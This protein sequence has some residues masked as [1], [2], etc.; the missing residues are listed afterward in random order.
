MADHSKKP[1]KKKASLIIFIVELLILLVL[2]T[3]IFGYAKINEGLRNIGT[4]GGRSQTATGTIELAAAND[5]TDAGVQAVQAGTVETTESAAAERE[6]SGEKAA[7]TA[8]GAETVSTASGEAS[9]TGD[10]AEDSSGKKKK[11]RKDKEKE[12]DQDKEKDKEKAESTGSAEEERA[13]T[14]AVNLKGEPVTH[15]SSGKDPNAD[16][17]AAEEN[18][19]IALNEKMRGYTNIVLVG[20]DTRDLNQIDY[21]N[22]DT[23]IIASINNNTGNIRMVSVYRDTLL[24]V[25]TDYSMSLPQGDSD[26]EFVSDADAVVVAGASSGEEDGEALVGGEDGG[27]DEIEYFDEGYDEGGYDEGDYDE[28]G[29]DE[30]GYDEGSDEGSYDEGGGEE[31]YDSEDASYDEEGEEDS[32][33]YDEDGGSSSSDDVSEYAENEYYNYTESGESSGQLGETTAAGRYDKANSAYANGST[34]Q[35]LQMLNKNLD[36]NIHDIVVVDFA[37]VAKLVDDIDGIDVHMTYE[38]VVHM[39]NY[40]QETSMVTGLE[41]TPIEPEELPREYHLNGV[42]AV[43]YARIRFT[44]GSDMKRTQRQR[45]VIHKIVNKARQRGLAAVQGMITDVLP[46]CKTSFST[47]EIIRMASQA[48]GYRIEATTGFPFEHIEKNVYVD[49]KQLDAVV[50]VTLETNV[51]ELHKFL[52]DE[53]DYECSATVKEY[54][55]DISVLSGLTE[56]SRD[57][58]VKNSQIGESGGEADVVI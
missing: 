20:I 19:G 6:V 55:N 26:E 31:E 14:G 46:L 15:L 52:F 57:V 5:A 11:D 32:G 43:S 37:A 50:P 17:D 7:E 38:E 3:A 40:C 18:E 42:Q 39:N 13:G 12:K 23:M 4:A 8:S 34:R 45:V 27:D 2:V 58:A 1:K 21:A 48:F 56:A 41:Y 30:G 29:D 47:A 51:K 54:S 33:E 16:G 24:N 53:D 22:S 35:L 44:N 10:D 49:T 36:L 28:G 25:Q 9:G